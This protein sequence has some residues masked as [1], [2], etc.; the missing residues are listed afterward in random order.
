MRKSRG[1]AIGMSVLALGC[2]L[3]P[4]ATASAAPILEL[5]GL[6]TACFGTDCSTFGSSASSGSPFSLTYTGGPFDVWTDASGAAGLSL[7]TLER[8]NVNLRDSTTPLAFTVNLQLA[9]PGGIVGG[10]NLLFTASIKG[11]SSGGGGPLAID[12]LNAWQLVTF[13][14]GTG[15]GSFEIGIL[16]DPSLPKNDTVSLLAS[17]RNASFTAAND[18]TQPETPATPMPEPASLLL[19]GAG[20]VG[21]VARRHRAR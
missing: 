17:V 8:D 11:T 19:V 21:A 15:A 20:I 1:R 12:F 18:S 9:T 3:A 13:A 16:T 10:Q 14:N 2:V 7:G 4:A 6:T 5:T